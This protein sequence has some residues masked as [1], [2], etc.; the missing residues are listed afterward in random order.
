MWGKQEVYTCTCWYAHTGCLNIMSHATCDMI[1][2]ADVY[3]AIVIFGQKA[4]CI[5][6]A[7]KHGTTAADGSVSACTCDVCAAA[8]MTTARATL[9]ITWRAL[10]SVAQTA[11]SLSHQSPN[12]S[13]SRNSSSSR[14]LL[15][16][17]HKQDTE[18]SLFWE[19]GHNLLP[20]Q[21]LSSCEGT[22]ATLGGC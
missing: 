6:N 15:L 4:W 16:C 5:R 13:S 3:A 20:S 17:W 22:E 8:G 2:H 12:P 9:N 1:R 10:A 11:A 7:C 19:T 14:M 21:T 18:Q